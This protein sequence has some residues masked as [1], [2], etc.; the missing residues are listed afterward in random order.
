ML[1]ASVRISGM[2]AAVA[3]WFWTGCGAAESGAGGV[4][5]EHSVT[6]WPDHGNSLVG[7]LL[8]NM[9]LLMQTLQGERRTSNFER[10]ALGIASV[11]RWKLDVQRS[12]F[13]FLPCSAPP[14]GAPA[15]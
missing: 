11:G 10:N 8:S 1:S 13:E 3:G 4:F 7:W 14:G 2:S 5:I 12:K 9:K 15:L 6:F